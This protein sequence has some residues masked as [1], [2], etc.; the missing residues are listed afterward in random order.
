MRLAVSQAEAV[1]V[2]VSVA[3]A[4]GVQER[5]RDILWY[6]AVTRHLLSN[7]QPELRGLDIMMWMR[8][9][10]ALLVRTVD[11]A[12]LVAEPG[13]LPSEI[14][15]LQ[16]AMPVLEKNGTLASRPDLLKKVAFPP[17]GPLIGTPLRNR[18][19]Q[20]FDEYHHTISDWH[21]FLDRP[22][23]VEGLLTCSY[24]DLE[25]VPDRVA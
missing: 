1:L 20:I 7:P 8:A 15:L 4:S 14:S 18:R 12:S 16:L 19:P 2:Q 22:A 5:F 10:G 6:R 25:A 23:T 11:R 13:D 24:Q 17:L 21:R 9:M 3:P